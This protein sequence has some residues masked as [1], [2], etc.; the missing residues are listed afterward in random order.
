MTQRLDSRQ[1]WLL[2]EYVVSLSGSRLHGRADLDA[3]DIFNVGLQLEAD[4]RFRRHVNII[5][6]SDLKAKQKSQAQKLARASR[7]VLVPNIA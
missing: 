1:L 3:L 6:W 4:N 2:G 7:P 5:G